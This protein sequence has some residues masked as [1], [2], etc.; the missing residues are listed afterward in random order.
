MHVSLKTI[1]K[2]AAPLT[3]LF[4]TL[5]ILLPLGRHTAGAVLCIGQDGHVA[6]EGVVGSTCASPYHNPAPSSAEECETPQNSP[7]HCGPCTDIPLPTG[8]D[9]DCASFKAESGLTA[10]VF[11]PLVA[12]LA[13]PILSETA[14]YTQRTRLEVLAAESPELASLRSTVLLL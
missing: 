6:T 11:L 8:G 12:V 14:W 5:L 1:K 7:S 2:K 9:V 13:T 4:A 10:Q 3:W